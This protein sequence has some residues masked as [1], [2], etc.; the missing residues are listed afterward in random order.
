VARHDIPIAPGILAHSAEEAVAA[1][2]QCGYPVVLKIVSPE[3]VH[4]WD[5]GGVLLEVDG[6]AAVL[7]GY[8]TLQARAEGDRPWSVLIQ[9]QIKGK[10]VLLGVKQDSTFGPVVVCGL[11]GI[12]TEVYKDVAQTLAPINEAQAQE[13]LAALR[14]YPL[15]QGVRGEAPAA[16]PELAR[17]LA[18][19]SRLAAAEPE[20]KEVDLNPV[21]VNHQGCWAVDARLVWEE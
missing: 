17:A 14:A 8:R 1:A 11:G 21:M 9:K 18:A 6:D 5:R 7:Q 15:L 16:L 13:L 2:R 19:L 10:E 12:Y 20:L 4:K 3:W